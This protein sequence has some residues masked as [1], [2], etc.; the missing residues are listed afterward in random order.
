MP[1][2]R[3]DLGSVLAAAMWG[4]WARVAIAGL[5]RTGVRVESGLPSQGLAR[6]G[7]AANAGLCMGDK[8]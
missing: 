1:P 2:A 5:V 6:E 7:W 4:E 8:P 3:I